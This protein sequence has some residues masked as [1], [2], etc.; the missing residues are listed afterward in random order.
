MERICFSEEEE[1][2]PILSSCFKSYRIFH[3]PLEW[4]WVCCLRSYFRHPHR[5]TGNSIYLSCSRRTVSHLQWHLVGLLRICVLRLKK[6]TKQEDILSP[7][8]LSLLLF[9]LLFLPLLLIILFTAILNYKQ[10]CNFNFD[11]IVWKNCI[12]VQWKFLLYLSW[13]NILGIWNKRSNYN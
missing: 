6:R 12:L 9:L 13:M 2:K 11:G 7:L 8:L 1:R 10:A 4:T 5:N 3:V